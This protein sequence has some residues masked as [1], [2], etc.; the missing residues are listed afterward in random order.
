MLPT[1]LVNLFAPTITYLQPAAPN[2]H[3]AFA[4]APRREPTSLF[5]IRL[6]LEQGRVSGP[7][8]IPNS[9]PENERTA[10]DNVSETYIR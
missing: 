9:P 4:M 3:M 6:E 5:D 1:L 2:T 7:E 10:A 8:D